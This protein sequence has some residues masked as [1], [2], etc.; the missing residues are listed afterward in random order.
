MKTSVIG[1]PRVGTLRELKFAV[2]KYFKSTLSKEELQKTAAELRK[3]HWKDQKAN[4]IDF[5]SSNDF[6]FYDN[7]LDTAVLLN[8]VPKKYKQ[9]RLDPLDEYFAMTRAIRAKRVM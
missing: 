6:S 5:I 2:E 7:L 3:K 4:E 8:A 1:Y 9:L